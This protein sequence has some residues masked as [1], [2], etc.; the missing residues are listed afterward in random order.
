MRVICYIYSCM[1]IK[2]LGAAGTVTGSCYYVETTGGEKFMVDCGFFQGKKELESINEKPFEVN[3]H[4]ISYLLLTHA[5]LD[6]C[7]RLAKLVKDGFRGE[8]YTTEATK[9]ILEV[10]L[11][12]AS[13]VYQEH[14]QERSL[15]NEDDV[16]QTLSQVRVVEYEKEFGTPNARITY[17]NAGHIL[18]SS[19]LEL[20]I[21]GKRVTFS[22]DLGNSPQEL[23][24]PTTPPT[25][26][27]LLILESTYGNRIHE[28]ENADLEIA[29]LLRDVADTNGV[30][31]IPAFSIERTQEL[32]FRLDRIEK[33]GKLPENIHVYMDSPMAQKVTDIFRDFPELYN[34]SLDNAA[35]KDDPFSFPNLIV[36]RS[37]GESKKIW[38]DNSAKVIIAGSGM[39][40]GGRIVN[41]VKKYISSESTSILFVGFQAEGTHGR[42]ILSGEKTLSIDGESI[43]VQAK[44]FDLTSL[45]SHADQPKLIN[46][47]SHTKAKKVILTH[48]EDEARNVLS[49]KIKEIEPTT[50]ITQPY[51]LE[52]FEI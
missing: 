39:V 18:G 49:T 34:Q 1:K 40:N 12:D 19:Y 23:I 32:L 2:F 5:H 3:P 6:H 7:G 45:S 36:T 21:D 41:H 47:F 28:S 9:R 20:A 51:Y 13:R 50:D 52:T 26:C 22:G 30:L 4:E 44:I 25:N 33:Q 11:L 48:G 24:E 10:S 31:L 37:S 43:P 8:I 46:F 15:F 29:N 38:D 27:D 16:F 42:Q 35:K 14:N 17:K